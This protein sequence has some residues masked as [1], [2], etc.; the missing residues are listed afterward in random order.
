MKSWQ[1]LL[2]G[3]LVQV[4]GGLVYIDQ[5]ISSTESGMRLFAFFLMGAPTVLGLLVS[6][7]L[8][9]APAF[10]LM[11]AGR[12]RRVAAGWSFTMAG[13]MGLAVAGGNELLS[14]GVIYPPA[15]ALAGV[16]VWLEHR[17]EDEP[18]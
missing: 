16:K 2:A 12:G 4:I 13:L 3:Y 18:R 9:T 1:I 15:V 10:V 17:S 7:G 8:L 11:L 6:A 14:F 5:V